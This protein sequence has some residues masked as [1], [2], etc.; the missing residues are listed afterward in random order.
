MIKRGL[1][2]LLVVFSFGMK[3][4]FPEHDSTYIYLF[5]GLAT[6]FSSRIVGKLAD[7]YGKQKIFMIAILFSL[8]PLF[9]ICNMPK[10]AIPY[11]ITVTT[12]FFIVVSG[13]MIPATTMI[14]STVLPQHRGGFMSI[15]SSVQQLSAGI[16]SF[17]SGAIV[18]KTSGGLLL[19]YNYVGYI[20]MAASILSIF[21]AQRIKSVDTVIKK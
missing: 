15:N 12:F 13:R 10:I 20:A 1:F 8:L 21:V 18:I 9:G 5:G 14:T 3:A 4:Q 16:A 7:K 11:V 6:F 19:N 2:F 17:V